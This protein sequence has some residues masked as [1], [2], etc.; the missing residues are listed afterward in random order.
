MC[1]QILLISCLLLIAITQSGCIGLYVQA[2]EECENETPYTGVHDFFYFKR[3][4]DSFYYKHFPPSSSTKDMFLDQWG[5]PDEIISTSEN[6]E[7]WIY[8]RRLWCGII[9]VFFL[10]VPL[11]LPVCDGFDRIEFKG[12][13]A[14]RL[15]TRL[16][17]RKGGVLGDKFQGQDDPICRFPLDSDVPD[18]PAQV[19]P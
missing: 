17:V 1:R 13:K 18:P 16:S 12:N 8:N 7:T 11:M 4:H 19:T 10:P 15:H 5:K 6:M 3:I 9:P 2:P 14:I